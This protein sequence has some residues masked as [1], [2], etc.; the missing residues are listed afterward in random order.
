ME[1]RIL[2][3]RGAS[4]MKEK[5]TSSIV[6]A[7]LLIGLITVAF[8]IPLFSI[9]SV[10]SESTLPPSLQ[11]LGG[12]IRFAAREG[13]SA[14]FVNFKDNYLTH[15]LTDGVNWTWFPES[16]MDRITVPVTYTLEQLGFSVTLAADIPD[17]LTLYDV[18]ILGAYYAIEP[19]HEPL[20]RDYI[21]NGGGVVLLFGTQ[22]YFGG[23]CKD[24]WPGRLGLDD[25]TP[26][27]EWFGA[28]YFV[29]SGGLA[30]ATIDNPLNTSLANGDLVYSALGSNSISAIT[31]MHTDSKIFARWEMGSTFAFNHQYGLGR[32]YYQATFDDV[33]QAPPPPTNTW[34]VTITTTPASSG[35]T[36]PSGTISVN[37]RLSVTAV[38][39]TGYQFDYWVFDSVNYG[40]SNPIIISEQGNETSHTLTAVFSQMVEPPPPPPPPAYARVSVVNPQTGDHY[41]VFYDNSTSA[42]AH[43]NASIWVSNVTDLYS[44]QIYLTIDDSMLN[45]TRVWIPTRYAQWVFYGKTAFSTPQ[46]LSDEDTDGYVEAVLFGESILGNG[47]PRFDG[48]GLLALI[49]F[50][51]TRAPIVGTNLFSVL[52]I[53]KSEP[54]ETF[55]LDSGAYEISCTMTNGQYA[56]YDPPPLI[57]DLTYDGKVDIKDLAIAAK[58]FGSYPGQAG[59]NAMADINKDN[60]I[61]II[62]LAMIAKNYGKQLL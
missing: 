7:L 21:N 59:W 56:F 12:G 52:D 5:S 9:P 36:S 62:D 6:T 3:Q 19:R 53:T 8:S 46:V 35:S 40:N 61:G 22:M 37:G 42:G 58:A 32:M 4:F 27:Q 39:N 2:E 14:L 44:Y 29:N 48:T 41:F 15:H 13:N 47:Q 38:P 17:N 25:L 23:Y 55:L 57:G 1:H 33:N 31:S 51:I 24:L 30:Y 60:T 18:V 45:I 34:S 26:V 20:I 50:E 43:F 54:Y 49:E 16:E 28:R 10:Q 11:L